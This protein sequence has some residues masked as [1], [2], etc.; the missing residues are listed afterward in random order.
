MLIKITKNLD[1]RNE[2]HRKKKFRAPVI[3]NRGVSNWADVKNDW[4]I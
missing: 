3:N 1:Y 2:N 4:F